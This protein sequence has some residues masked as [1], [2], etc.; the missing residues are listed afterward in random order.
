[1]TSFF[2]SLSHLGSRIPEIIL[3]LTILAVVLILVLGFITTYSIKQAE[4]K[5]PA[6]PKETTPKEKIT[7]EYRMPP[8]GGLLAQ[9]LTLRGTF[10]VGDISLSFLRVLAFL[11]S[12]LDRLT[13]K[14]Q[15]PWY[16][17]VGAS[18]SGKSTLLE[19]SGMSLPVGM[20]D[21]G[22]KNPHTACRWWF[23]NRAVVLD[24]HGSLVIEEHKAA[25]D[26][27]GWRTILNLLGRYRAKR[28]LDGIILTI[29]A[30]ELYGKERLSPENINARAKFLSQKLTAAQ[31]LL[32]LR[33][34][35]YVIIT[36]CDILPGFQSFCH[37]LPVAQHTNMLG[38]SVPYAL[39][40]AYT[41]QWVDEAFQTI[42][43]DLSNVQ[44]EMFANGVAAEN[45]DGILI[46]T[47]E[48]TSLKDGLKLYLDHIFKGSAYEE[49]L[50]LRGIYFTGDSGFVPSGI[51]MTEDLENK[52]EDTE[53]RNEL[54]LSTQPR[55]IADDFPQLWD[56]HNDTPN[57]LTR[58]SRLTSGQVY[59]TE[60]SQY[61]DSPTHHIFFG[62]DIF[63]DKIFFESGLAYPIYSR[64]VSANRNINFAKAGMVAFVGIG[65]FGMINAYENF[66]KN[67]DYLMPVLG[68][69]N[70]L[71]QQLPT[72]QAGETKAPEAMFTN[73]AKSLL[74]MMNHIQRASFFS[75]FIPSSW[76]SPLQD[77]LNS[78]LKI[79]YEQ[80][81]LRT[82]YM[83]LLLRARDILNIR[84]GD[85]ALGSQP[86]TTAIGTLLNPL[87]T[88]E[89]QQFKNYV[90]EIGM[91]VQ[92]IDKY[93]RLRETPE[94]SVLTELIEY[95]FNIQLPPEFSASYE[96]FRKVLQEAP[97]PPIDLKSYYPIAQNTLQALYMNFLSVLFSPGDPMS[98][99]G[100]LRYLTSTIAKAQTNAPLNLDLIRGF[101]TGLGQSL[102][103]LGEVGHNW[104]DG[105]YFNPG[106]EFSEIMGKIDSL[107]PFGSAI[108][109]QLAQQTSTVY[110][111]FHE[112]LLQM[113]TL[114][115][116]AAA[117][118]AKPSLPSEG[119]FNLEKN[120]HKLFAEPF[121]AKTSGQMFTT[122]VPENKLALW[123]H[124]LIEDT[125]NLIKRYEAFVEKDLN[126]F[127]IH[128]RETFKQIALQNLQQNVIS[129]IAR[130]QSFIDI[131]TGMQ[132]GDTNEEVLRTAIGD[133]SKSTPAFIKLLE[134]LNKMQNGT[135]FVEMQN[136]LG[137]LA[138]RLLEKVDALLIA[139]HPYTVR[140]NSFD[141]WDGKSSVFLDGFGVKDPDELKSYLDHQRQQISHLAI[142]YAQPL[143]KLLGSDMMKAFAG[144]RAL[145]NRWT[146]IINDLSD[147]DK[148]KPDNAVSTLENLIE[149]DANN[150]SMS[151]CFE[152]FTLVSA[153]KTSGDFFKDRRL[154]LQRA[155]MSRCEIAK[156]QDSIKN[157]EKLV[158][159]FNDSLKD[160]FPFVG[161]GGTTTDQAEA[162]PEDIKTFFK[163]FHDYGNT[164]KHVL[165][166]IYQLG[167]S[168]KEPYQFLKD[169][170]G[171]REFLQVYLNSK[172]PGD[173][174]SFDFTID[175]RVN[176]EKEV[177]GNM[178]IEW[179]IAPSENSTIT[180]NDKKKTGRW[181]YGSPVT[182]TLRWPDSAE[183]QP[184]LDEAQ[185]YMAVDE[186]TVTFTYPG[187][188]SMLQLLRSQ[189]SS[190]SDFESMKDQNP[191]TL[192]FEVPNGPEEKTV[193][194][195]RIVLNKPGKG[196]KPGAVVSVPT[197]P[198]E[199]PSLDQNI[200]DM[201]EKPAIV[202][203][204]VEPDPEII[205]DIE[206]REKEAKKEPKKKKAE[207]EAPE[208]PAPEEKPAKP[209]K[210]G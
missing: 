147:F 70:S 55:S 22:L 34:P 177:G 110:K 109:E 154:Q 163:L 100:Q 169:M 188:W 37:E 103:N 59:T 27:H 17:M 132:V 102:P 197:F 138:T 187:Q 77:Q 191:Y 46:L 66:M 186:Q 200:L 178:I 53:L 143:I 162:D 210:G 75:F 52:E 142:D 68:K 193:V 128:L 120:L 74:E 73:Q 71:L 61:S 92:N 58:L 124:N 31:H 56:E 131:P 97:Y 125:I 179:S 8:L 134:T 184:F 89:Y 153:K 156:R 190:S 164:P 86:K 148:K 36:K 106:P 49:S 26:E 107:P 170:E 3:I 96:K 168:A 14:Y 78:S 192:R 47:N 195:N 141:W 81:I 63:E 198:T 38:W 181:T 203:G 11:R 127:P 130:S 140:D 2:H 118:G 32:G 94:P 119:I 171:V 29:S 204:L 40:S 145:I 51:L 19:C 159:V 202:Q 28:P 44:L 13:Y 117:P 146:R 135:V 39:H 48:F 158:Q 136:L 123:N 82:I 83:D 25:A 91:L 182:V 189:Q 57:R 64:L 9:F 4:K 112:E 101:I 209:E 7:P 208:E 69:V 205:E 50:M 72:A 180:N 24:I 116:N 185:P 155:L 80:I 10:R 206:K 79:S 166:Q 126:S 12:R 108:V 160:K 173:T 113:N 122:Q 161:E 95:T 42:S 175:F 88:S 199:A 105:E 20:P 144:K 129:D 90:D 172:L 194:Y 65:T 183:M 121:M 41:P 133:I 23:Y 93:N 176:K 151:N 18:A 87:T 139:Y 114:L 62:K 104:I 6:K 45:G 33:L 84:P 30:S 35:V 5:G 207:E 1:M 150:L 196:K 43:D 60:E 167:A 157:Y 54:S 98:L 201:S 21:F 174:P 16:L 137:V 15:L 149:K 67:R 99:I 165:D 111:A 152:K 76:F 115:I 85:T